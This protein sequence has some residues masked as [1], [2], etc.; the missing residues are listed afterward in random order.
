MERPR[1]VGSRLPRLSSF[2]LS[3][4]RLEKLR[5]P[6]Q[7]GGLVILDGRQLLDDS[8]QLRLDEIRGRIDRRLVRLPELRRCVYFPGLLRGRALWVDDA[9]F[10]IRNH[11]LEASVPPPGGEPQLLDTAAKLYGKLLVRSRPLWELW[12]LSGL[13]DGRVGALLKLHHSVADGMAAVAIMGSLFD[14]E[15]DSPEP[16]AEPWWPAAIPGS[17][18]LISDSFSTKLSALKSGLSTAAHPARQLRALRTF[19]VGASQA[20]RQRRSAPMTSINQA[21]K[22]GRRIRFLR[23]ELDAVRDRAHAA[24]AKVNDVFLD[25]VAGG[26]RQL[27]RA[28]GEEVA[29]GELIGTVAV[30]LRPSS[31]ARELGNQ[32]GLLTV[33]LPVGEGDSG[34]R[35]EL[36]AAAARQA[37][38]EQHA[39]AVPTAVG[40]LA[41]TPI[42][43]YLMA[44]Q[45]WVNVF[46]TNLVG[47]PVPVYVVGAEILDVVPI[48]QVAG[49]VTLAFCAFSYAGRFYLVV[50]AD[51]TAVPDVDVL[52][53]GME[54]A[55]RQLAPPARLDMVAAT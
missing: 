51:A 44:H 8:G 12:F 9:D 31:E 27:L 39:G 18:E 14:F 22:P 33:P 4:L 46:T 3:N 5:A 17:W 16:L 35:L 24:D 48:I 29:G 30:S 40:G 36:I 15:A 6:F 26:L 23:L 28:R 55:W 43:Q 21:V 37:K 50:T 41:A 34:R 11:V 47:P 25:L 1:R 2:D 52:I 13:S 54:H 38:A 49:N 45:H 19:I 32:V 53:A 7:I 10:D 20:L 42:A